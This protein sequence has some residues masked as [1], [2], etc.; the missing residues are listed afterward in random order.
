MAIRILMEITRLN[1]V[2]DKNGIPRK[3]CKTRIMNKG[4]RCVY[5]LKV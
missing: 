5:V 1:G 2:E 4:A 3:C